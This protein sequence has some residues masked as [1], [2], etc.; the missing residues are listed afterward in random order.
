M[1]WSNDII[2]ELTKKSKPGL[3]ESGVVF[4]RKG[5]PTSREC[6][7]VSRMM[8][9]TERLLQEGRGRPGKHTS[10]FSNSF[11]G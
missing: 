5:V 1:G 3:R 2:L 6:F 7:G 9:G 10:S 4:K 11:L 8:V